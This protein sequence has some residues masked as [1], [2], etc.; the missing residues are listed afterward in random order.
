MQIIETTEMED[1]GL[2]ITV[3]VEAHMLPPLAA[4]GLKYAVVSA[5]ML[6][7]GGVVDDAENDSDIETVNRTLSSQVQKLMAE[8]KDADAVIRSLRAE[9]AEAHR[10]ADVERG[11]G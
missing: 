3:Q 4:L 9:L 8:L 1:G 11:R 5:A 2:Q 10:A 7:T 6:E